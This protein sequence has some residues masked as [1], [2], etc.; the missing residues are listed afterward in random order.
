VKNVTAV[1]KSIAKHPYLILT[2]WCV[3]V[4]TVWFLQDQSPGIYFSDSW[5]YIVVP[6]TPGLASDSLHSS[7]IYYVWETLSFGHTNAVNII[8]IQSLLGVVSCLILFTTIRVRCSF[9]RSLLIAG[10]FGAIP[11]LAFFERSFMTESICTT[12]ITILVYIIVQTWSQKK[13]R[14]MPFLILLVVGVG[15]VSGVLIG[16]RP[17]MQ[18]VAILLVLSF[19]VIAYKRVSAQYSWPRMALLAMILLCSAVAPALPMMVKN[20]RDYGVFSLSPAIGSGLV[21]RWHFLIPCTSNHAPESLSLRLQLII[22]EECSIRLQG[23]H[24]SALWFG[25]ELSK[26]MDPQPGFAALQGEMT[27]YA[28]NLVFANSR[29]STMSIFRSFYQLFYS[30]TVNTEMY[31]NGYEFYSSAAS[32]SNFYDRL[33]W[34]DGNVPSE[35]PSFVLLMN[36]VRATATVP[37]LILFVTVL[38]YLLY[39]M[40]LSEPGSHFKER[41]RQDIL[42]GSIFLSIVLAGA[43]AVAVGGGAVFRYTLPFLPMLLVALAFSW[44]SDPSAEDSDDV[45]E[46]R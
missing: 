11:G 20:S 14:S 46:S 29:L 28:R 27:T 10:I 15:I 24:D 32:V 43:I 3:A 21:A 26:S 18:V 33:A 23:H 9:Y 41:R 39:W 38:M 19:L 37:G 45:E 2:G 44:P 22:E 16:I 7:Y 25:G 17:P 36:A 1:H 12:L 6:R 40:R 13:P 31:S 30:P 8:A 42:L 4:R 34:F 35:G 5:D